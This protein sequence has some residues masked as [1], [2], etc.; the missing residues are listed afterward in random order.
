MNEEILVITSLALAN[1]YPGVTD[2]T[3]RQLIKE[4]VH[5]FQKITVRMLLPQATEAVVQ[6]WGYTDACGVNH[7]RYKTEKHQW[8]VCPC[9]AADEK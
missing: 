1:L 9:I 6:A 7:C 8:K 3:I 4:E 5:V 2:L